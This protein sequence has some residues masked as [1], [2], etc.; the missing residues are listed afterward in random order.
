MRPTL[1]C[2]IFVVLNNYPGIFSWLSQISVF[3]IS[4]RNERVHTYDGYARF[5]WGEWDGN[6][7]EY[8]RNARTEDVAFVGEVLLRANRAN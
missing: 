3:F 7:E 8:R 6:E 5:L 4:S 2:A 1:L